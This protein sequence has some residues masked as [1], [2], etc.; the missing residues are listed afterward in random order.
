[1]ES[2]KDTIFKFLRLDNL[3]ENLSGYME[4]RIELLK[5]EIREDV[6]KVLAQALMVVTILF[7]ALIF[8]LFFSVGLAHF[9]N[10]FFE[11]P[12]IGYWIVAGIY[13]IPC[14]IF[15][16]FRKKIGHSFEQHLM[17]KIKTKRKE[18]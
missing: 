10:S 14:L 3:I 8:M 9:L 17:E 7:L 5:I 2:I 11:Q 18:K 6:A 12:Y 15:I 16:V 4:A 13:G 1:M